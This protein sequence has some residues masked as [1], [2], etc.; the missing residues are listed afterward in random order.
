MKSFFCKN[1]K[2][3]LILL[4]AFVLPLVITCVVFAYNGVVPFG[5][6]S[7][8]LWDAKIQYKDYFGYL[9][10]VLHGNANIMY[11]SG[12]SLGGNTV[13]LVAYY[14]T[15]PLNLFIYFFDKT[16]ISL[17]ISLLTIVKIALCGVTSAYF[18]N[19]RFNINSVATVLLS[20]SYAL[21]E[22]NVVYSSN[23]MWL[24]GAVL[25]PLICL[26][27]Y[28]MLYERKKGMLFFF[29]F[30]S[31]VSNWYSGYMACLMAGF[32][33]L[34]E[35]TL[36]HDWKSFKRIYKKILSDCFAVGGDMVLGVLAGCAVL[37]PAL[38][39]LVGGKAK[40]MPFYLEFNYDPFRLFEG[41]DINAYANAREAPILYCGGLALVLVVY[42]FFDR[43][44]KVKK[45]VTTLVYFIF[46]LLGFLVTAFEFIWTA[47]VRSNSYQYRF[48]FVFAFLM[49]MI[50]SMAVRSIQDNENTLDN[51]A[52]LK[53]LGVILGVVIIL[54]ITNN[55]RNRAVANTYFCIYGVYALLI[56]FAFGFKKIN[57]KSQKA[58]RAVSCVLISAF[59]VGELG[60]NAHLAFKTFYTREDNFIAYIDSMGSVVDEMKQKDESFYRFE[61][62]YSY[63]LIEDY[64]AA[65]CESLMFGYNSIENYSSTYDPYLDEFLASMGYSDPTYI[66]PEDA[67]KEHL[68]FPTDTY[69][70]SPMLLMDSLLG[71]K[72]E[73]AQN[74]SFGMEKTEFDAKLPDGYSMYK[75][76]YAL[77]MAYNVSRNLEMKPEYS[78]NPFENQQAFLS[79]MLGRDVDAYVA[80]DIEYLGLDNRIDS[81]TVVANTD[82]PMY[83]YTD[84]TRIHLD[85]YNR[86]CELIVNGEF[87]SHMCQRF[88]INAVYIGDYKKGDVINV[89]LKHVSAYDDRHE[90]YAAQLDADIFE[91][92]YKELS[93]GC[94][95]NLNIHGGNISGYYKT[96]EDSL[97]MLTV[98]YDIGWRAYVDGEKVQTKRIAD[99]FLGL[100]LTAGRHEIEMK[101]VTP[102]FSEGIAA[103]AIGFIGFAAWCIIDA[104]IRKKK[105]KAL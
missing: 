37:I 99:T 16:Q 74:K 1:K 69:W 85:R 68:L 94:E 75:N 91:C 28:R 104:A 21:M 61:K 90:V 31:I 39:S 47:F 42:F 23:I 19:K 70:N 73:L 105:S 78:L 49:I 33:F 96:D 52:L 25:L 97:V 26:G 84:G 92:V 86:N 41:F 46:V 34:Y 22:Y 12:K 83:F 40:F 6:K 51:K 50:A 89:Q 88:L 80:P 48:A 95:T 82:G 20:A 101:Y 57:G 17:F 3:I 32:Y 98:P 38:F 35:L 2:T 4:A 60:Y 14:L 76:P 58:V 53:A 77:D 79:A 5:N 62:N 66:P 93:S 64:D 44:I 30:M 10:D 81:Y 71:V 13:S 55:L 36:K 7:V 65:T 59:L 9:W 43:R 8:I 27:V 87:V 72:Y 54:N 29:V 103:S 45:R 18:I 67:V 56:F 15:C 63:L 100:E 24:D 102:Y 11:S